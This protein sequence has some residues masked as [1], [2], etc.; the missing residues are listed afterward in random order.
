MEKSER[1]QKPIMEKAAAAFGIEV[2][3]LVGSYED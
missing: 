1:L 2:A 3:R